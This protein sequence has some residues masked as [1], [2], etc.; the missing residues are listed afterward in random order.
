MHLDTFSLVIL[1]I[2]DNFLLF[3][4]YSFSM[5]TLNSTKQT[6]VFRKEFIY[7]TRY[8]SSSQRLSLT[9]HLYTF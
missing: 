3:K 8:C 1:L 5:I 6:I 2:Y 9:I 4:T 7:N